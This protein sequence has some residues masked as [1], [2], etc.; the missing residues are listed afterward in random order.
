V[1]HHQAFAFDA[2]LI[3][4]DRL[5]PIT[6]LSLTPAMW[7]TAIESICSS[8]IEHEMYGT[9]FETE[10]GGSTVPSQSPPIRVEHTGVL[11]G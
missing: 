1:N 2:N 6:L 9:Q 4:L 5:I 7:V 8:P 10:M 11:Q 3:Q